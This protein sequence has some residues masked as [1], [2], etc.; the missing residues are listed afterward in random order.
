MKTYDVTLTL[1]YNGSMT[2]QAEDEEQA[3][4]IAQENLNNKTLKDFPNGV[5]IP[6]GSFTFGEATADYASLS[7]TDSE[8]NGT[9]TKSP[10]IEHMVISD[11]RTVD[12]RK[13]H[14]PEL[15]TDV[16]VSSE[17]VRESLY[18][19]V[20]DEYDADDDLFYGYVPDHEFNTLTDDE[21]QTWVNKHLN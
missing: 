14:V 6:N 18:N 11:G 9:D 16:L 5:E 15:G 1:I 4:K 21:L 3:L 10:T 17:T 20:T 13:V 7:E 8:P 2:V 12:V 19:E